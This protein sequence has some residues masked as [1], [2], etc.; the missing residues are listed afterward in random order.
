MKFIFSLYEL[1]YRE[2]PSFSQGFSNFLSGEGRRE[3][4]LPD[5]SGEH[6]TRSRKILNKK[7]EILV[8]RVFFC[9]QF[10]ETFLNKTIKSWLRRVLR[11]RRRRIFLPLSIGYNDIFPI[12]G[13][14][15]REQAIGSTGQERKFDLAQNKPR[16]KILEHV[17]QR[18]TI[19][20]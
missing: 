5:F 12:R 19:W 1:P 16:C 18:C 17:G 6:F 8:Y 9:I 10:L 20:A 3:S 2:G 13:G 11:H 7:V 14:G 15:V 4:L